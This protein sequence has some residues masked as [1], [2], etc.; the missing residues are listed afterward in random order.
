MLPEHDLL[1]VDEA[2]ELVDRVTAT[3]TDELSQGMVS[4]AARRAAR[5]ADGTDE[6][7]DAAV[8]LGGVLEE[9]P[10]GRMAG[11]SDGLVLAL[12]RVRDTTRSVQ[13][14]LKPPPGEQPDGSR[15]VAR[16]A[17]DE[18]YENSARILEGRDLDVV[19]LSKDPRRGPVLRVAPMSVAMLVRD[20][21]FGDR[22]VI[23]TSATLELGGSFDAVAG[24]IGLRGEGA[25]DWRG[26]DVGSP[27]DY[28]RQAI[29]Y[30]AKDLPAPGRDGTSPRVLDEIEALVRAAGGRTLGLFSSTRAAQNAAEQLRARFATDG[31]DIDILCQGEDQIATLVRQFAREPMT[32]LFGTLTLWQ[33][34]DVPGSSCQLVVIDRIPFPRPDD[35]LASA[36]AEAIARMGGNGFMAV[37]ATHAALRLAQG[38]G[39]LVRRSDDRGVVA[40]LDSRMV[41][42]RYAGF[43]Q[44]SLPPFWPTTDRD[45]VVAALRRLDEVAPPPLAV[46][47]PALRGIVGA[48]DGTADGGVTQGAEAASTDPGVDHRP[49]AGPPPTPV[50][51]RSAVTIG[52]AWTGDQD[53]ELRDAVEAGI[54]M[55]DL[56]DHLELPLDVVRARLDQLGLELN[57]SPR[58]L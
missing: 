11:L 32:C 16:A 17:I 57:D 20:K 2:H 44:R 10:E 52:H 22:T 15:Q 24:T 49:V 50:S 28:Q 34:V 19:W 51:T 26:L 42:A 56:I 46:A 39:R 54:D 1:V 18:M 29:V 38:S 33:G 47:D 3:I 31:T 58:L 53:A 43:L 21:V 37:S 55:D 40:I 4:G 7:E 23:L 13:S 45:L 27:F 25:P 5:L 41:S 48:V 36:R 14:E 8:L 6:V 12:S 9:L 30:V 35:P